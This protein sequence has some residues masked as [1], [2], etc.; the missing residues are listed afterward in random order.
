M[1]LVE[2]ERSIGCRV[3][4]LRFSVVRASGKF[5]DLSLITRIRKLT[6]E[7]GTLL[8]SHHVSGFRSLQ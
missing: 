2:R 4:R 5:P 1:L 8:V 7:F 6:S 3:S